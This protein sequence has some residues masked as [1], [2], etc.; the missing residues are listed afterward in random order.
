MAVS[1]GS[2]SY[3][4]SFTPISN[5]SVDDCD[6]RGKQIVGVETTCLQDAETNYINRDER[7]DDQK[8]SDKSVMYYFHS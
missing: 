1:G 3:F 8:D 2:R 4:P 6:D 7:Q 5:I